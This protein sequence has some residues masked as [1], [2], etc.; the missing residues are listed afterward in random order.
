M[1]CCCCENKVIKKWNL[2]TIAWLVSFKSDH[3]NQIKSSRNFE[4]KIQIKWST[5]TQSSLDEWMKPMM[6]TF[7]KKMNKFCN[8][9][10][11]PHDQV[12]RTTVFRPKY[13]CVWLKILFLVFLGWFMMIMMMMMIH[14]YKQPKLINQK[15]KKNNKRI[16]NVR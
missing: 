14:A 16:L 4:Y 2:Y 11:C 7:K 3:E 8:Y 9:F 1:C 10:N 13:V 15:K 5:N 6:L 12:K